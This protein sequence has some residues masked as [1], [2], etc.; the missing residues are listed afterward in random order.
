[1]VWLE[2]SYLLVPLMWI[3]CVELSTEYI[4]VD[5]SYENPEC[6]SSGQ[7]CIQEKRYPNLWEVNHPYGAADGWDETVDSFDELRAMVD[8]FDDDLNVVYRWDWI[9]ES[10][11]LHT[12]GYV[13]DEPPYAETFRVHL[14]QPRKSRFGTVECPIT[15]DQESEV[16]EWLA[17]ARCFGYLKRLWFPIMGDSGISVEDRKSL[18]ESAKEWS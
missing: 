7:M 13:G 5:G 10:N 18:T 14:L 2:L 4:V 6:N 11:P 12:D 1:M 8:G 16:R 17:G 9:D 3:G 15:K